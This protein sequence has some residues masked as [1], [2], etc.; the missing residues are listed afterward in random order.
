MA[1]ARGCRQKGV[2]TGQIV[3]VRGWPGPYDIVTA[4]REGA[5]P[6]R[7]CADVQDIQQ[8]ELHKD[9]RNTN[10]KRMR[11]K[12]ESKPCFEVCKHTRRSILLHTALEVP[13]AL[14]SAWE[15]PFG[16]ASGKASA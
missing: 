1:N 4:G 3:V 12:S 11:T 7:T 5:A 9:H 6:F 13:F 15:V 2:D 10:E 16:W 8:N 14:A